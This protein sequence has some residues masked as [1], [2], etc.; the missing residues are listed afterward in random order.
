MSDTARG[1]VSI[2]ISKDAYDSLTRIS[3]KKST[4]YSS[5]KRNLEY[6]I[7]TWELLNSKI[8]GGIPHLL[9]GGLIAIN[10]DDEHDTEI[11]LKESNK[12]FVIYT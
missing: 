11:E 12:S 6:I 10:L 9:G 1:L 5:K 3:N 8:C 7:K 2:K 4:K